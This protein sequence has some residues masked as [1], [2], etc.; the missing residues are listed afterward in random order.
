[1]IRALVLVGALG[2]Y[3][4]RYVGLV[5]S[6]AFACGYNCGGLGALIVSGAIAVLSS[7]PWRA[8]DLDEV[9]PRVQEFSG[10]VMVSTGMFLGYLMVRAI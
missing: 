5:K 3:L 10:W 4:W 2:W 7:A 9:Q 6:G 1:M 8:R